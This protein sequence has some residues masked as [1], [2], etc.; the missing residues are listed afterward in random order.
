[1][2]YY[3]YVNRNAQ[4]GGEHEVHRED[5]SY[6]PIETNRVHLGLYSS[7]KPAVEA[8]K[9]LYSNVDGGFFCCRDCHTR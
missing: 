9:K 6:L 2:F 4:V 1:M 5:C 3:Y 7:C 8:A